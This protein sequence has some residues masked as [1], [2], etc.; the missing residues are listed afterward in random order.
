MNIRI[1][2]YTETTTRTVELAVT[3]DTQAEADAKVSVGP[4]DRVLTKEGVEPILV[5]SEESY[6]IEEGERI[7]AQ[8]R[9]TSKEL[10]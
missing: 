3:A 2:R 10:P 7:V 6:R 1:Y 8:C 4:L 9:T 5:Q